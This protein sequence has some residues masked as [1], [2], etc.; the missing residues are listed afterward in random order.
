MRLRVAFALVLGFLCVAA[1]VA[2]PVGARQTCDELAALVDAVVCPL[3][4]SSFYAVGEW[5]VDFAP[6]TDEEIRKLLAPGRQEP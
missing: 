6:P 4:P 2:V 5:Y 3:T 1:R